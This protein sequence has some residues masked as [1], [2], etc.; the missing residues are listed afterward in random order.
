MARLSLTD[1]DLS[2]AGLSAIGEAT[3]AAT[4]TK[5]INTWIGGDKYKN[6]QT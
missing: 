3:A 6:K 5:A 1:S 2:A 4:S